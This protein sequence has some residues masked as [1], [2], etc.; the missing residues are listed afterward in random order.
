MKLFERVSVK[1][2]TAFSC[3]IILSIVLGVFSLVRM[4]AI[5]SDST[6]MNDNWI[7]SLVNI[8]KIN[9]ATSDFRIA[10][11]QHTLS[12]TEKSMQRFEQDM[13]AQLALIAEAEKKYVPLISSETEQAMFDRF[14][15]MWKRYMT[16]HAKFLDMSRNNR[17][18]EA[19]AL[20]RGEGQELFDKAS[21]TLGEL[22]QLNNEGANEQSAMGDANYESAKLWVICILLSVVV[23]S[24]ILSLFIVRSLLNQLGE[25]PARLADIAGRIAG[26]DLTVNLNTGKKSVGVF[27][28]MQ[29]MVEQLQGVV[30]NI[31]QAADNVAAGSVQISSAAEETSQGATEQAATAEE[32]SSSM[33][34]M[35]SNIEQNADNAHKTEEIARQ[36][37]QDARQ[38][39]EAV[40]QTVGAMKEIADKISIIEEI[41]RQTN[42]L[43]LNAAI[44]AARAG[45][46]GKG[47]AVVAAEVRKL[48][49]RSGTAASEI[50]ELSSTSVQIA[51]NAGA[52]LTSL[53][54]NIEKTA[55]LV[56]EIAAASAEQNSGAEQISAAI[57]QLDTVIQ[58]S[59]S[60]SEEM[61]S[62][63][64]ELSAQ[65]QEMQM[66]MEFFKLADTRNAP[67]A[68]RVK[69]ASKPRAALAQGRLQ[70]PV[71]SVARSVDLNMSDDSESEFERF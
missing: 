68:S 20:L 4:S 54:P 1:L 47:F 15:E 56:Q 18:D 38:G 61:A 19:K 44:E 36:S 2:G 10:E 16:L 66:T 29:Q 52:L 8:N 57:V 48:A 40:T 32:V 71:K 60:A 34:E 50:S 30:G 53:V 59:A 46:H 12:M 39:G 13:D 23:I 43:A 65:A 70:K 45:E 49:E 42:L 28:A 9:T 33:E 6:I 31:L 69:V 41:A 5:N 22:I 7:P 21:A 64:E 24:V 58:Q 14:M 63:S 17:T 3:T 27:A 35:V 37:A 26:G 11:L 51:E 55:E 25:E 67:G 62:A